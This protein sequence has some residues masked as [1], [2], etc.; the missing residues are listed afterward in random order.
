M[1][2]EVPSEPPAPTVTVI[3]F[4]KACMHVDGVAK[5]VHRGEEDIVLEEGQ[6]PMAGSMHGEGLEDCLVCRLAYMHMQTAIGRALIDN[7]HE[8]VT[9][10]R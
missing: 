1:T 7:N 3:P 4:T 2:R 10:A 9:P 6:I 5:W 8:Y